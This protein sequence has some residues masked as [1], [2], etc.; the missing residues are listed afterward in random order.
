MTFIKNMAKIQ[1]KPHLIDIQRVKNPSGGRSSFLRLDKNENTI[2]FGNE[3]T[4]IFKNQITS[5]FLSAYP[6]VDN[7]YNKIAN[8]LS[9]GEE[10]IYIASG[11]DAVIKAVFEVFVGKGDKVALLHPTYAMYYVYREIFQAEPVNIGFKEDLSQDLGDILNLIEKEKPKLVCLANPNAPTGTII[12]QDGLKKIMDLC[13]KNDAV[14][15]ID[16]AYYP[17]YPHSAI[18]LISD[19][20]NLIISRT[21][22]K[23]MGLAS[24]RLGFAAG[25][26]E[27]IDCLHKVRPMYETNAFAARFGEIILDNYHI[28]KKNITEVSDAKLYLEKELDGLHLPYFKSYANF[29]LINTA[30]LKRTLWIK[31]EMKKRKILIA[32]GFKTFPLENYIR[33]SI[34]SKD[35]MEYF[36]NNL[37]QIINAK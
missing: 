10:N 34:G 4:E 16:E 28:V 5:E 12:Q 1:A 31:D 9:I 33:V 13:L 36:I 27:I 19:Y 6:E 3:L 15:L 30:S 18:S 29:V 32:A 22:S 20:P 14:V 17:Y 26:R 21:F 25:S 23:A 35:Q 2:D 11:S 8:H 37:K 24:A 7:L